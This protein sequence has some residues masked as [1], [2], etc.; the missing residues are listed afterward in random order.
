MV[1]QT[2]SGHLITFVP[3]PEVE[4]FLNKLKVLAK[5]S[6]KTEK[7]LILFTYS[8]DNPILDPNLVSGRG[9]VTKETLKNP[10]YYIMV[11]LL[12]RKAV[13]EQGIDLDLIS[14][15]FT[16]TISEAAKE[17]GVHVSAIRQAILAHRL[18]SWKKNHK[19][20]LNR[21]SLSAFKL[22]LRSS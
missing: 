11:D 9:Y 15:G 20:Y 1:H 17:L 14:D 3:T 4:I 21:R 18:P 2:V 19:H 7:D 10:A 5:D 13:D 16:I 6:N 22:T 8:P 12:Y